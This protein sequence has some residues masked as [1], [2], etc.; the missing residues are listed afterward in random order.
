MA[1]SDDLHPMFKDMLKRSD[2]WNSH[3]NESSLDYNFMTRHSDMSIVFLTFTGMAVVIGNIGNILVIGAVLS[4]RRLLRNIGTMFIVNLA[5][6]DLCITAI[7]GPMNM[8]GVIKGP[9]F[10]LDKVTLCY[11]LGS[12]CTVSCIVS[13]WSIAAVAVN[14]VVCICKFFMYHR[15]YSRCKTILYCAALW[16][17]AILLD[18]P[19]WLG[20]GGHTFGLKEMGCTFDRVANH[21]YTIFLASM[22]IAVP[23]II[24]MASYLTLFLYV[25]KSSTNLERIGGRRYSKVNGSM[26]RANDNTR[27]QVKKE[28]L[29]LAFTLFLTFIVFVICWGPY[30]IAI[31]VDHKDEWPKEVYVVGTLLGHSNS[32]LNSIIY[33]MCN[34]RFRQGYYVFV[35]KTFCLQITRASILK[36]SRTAS[37]PKYKSNSSKTKTTESKP[38]YRDSIYQEAVGISK[39]S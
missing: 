3:N 15:I 8:T 10:F 24:V 26:Q 7:V 5:I 11:L 32:C 27:G 21:S 4:Y 12:I 39:G 18:L 34:K 22:S 19:N 31:T 9:K 6:A 20:W 38:G 13:M 23:M 36:E 30:M 14:R 2:G 29:Q 25:R 28:D 37:F 35:H 33:A 17:F 16:V 1:S